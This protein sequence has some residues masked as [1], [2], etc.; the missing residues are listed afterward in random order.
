MDKRKRLA[1]VGMTRWG[2]TN[3]HFIK[4]VAWML[5]VA[6]IVRPLHHIIFL[7]NTVWVIPFKCHQPADTFLTTLW[8]QVSWFSCIMFGELCVSCLPDA[9]RL[10]FLSHVSL[11]LGRMSAH[12]SYFVTLKSTEMLRRH[13]A[14]GCD[15]R[16]EHSN[17][18]VV[19]T[20]TA[21][22]FVWEKR[23]T[24]LNCE[25]ICARA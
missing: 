13:V 6:V 1:V 21:S 12:L 9:Q 11:L 17:V 24:K 8:L 15:I 18:K 16:I 14:H 19:H 3:A 25:P 2:T 22:I 10:C 20:C 7:F 23:K 4:M 5:I